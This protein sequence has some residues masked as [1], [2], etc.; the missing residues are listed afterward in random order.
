[1]RVPHRN[2]RS[3][4]LVGTGNPTRDDD[5]RHAERVLSSPQHRDRRRRK[6]RT[7][8]V[9]GDL[10]VLPDRDGKEARARRHTVRTR[11]KLAAGVQPCAKASQAVPAHL[12]FGPI[13]VPHPHGDG[14]QATVRIVR[15]QQKSIRADPEMAV[16]RRLRDPRH[17]LPTIA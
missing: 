10:A 8:H 9:Y 2:A 15:C 17:N 12:A 1:M 4:D 5:R 3:D 6:P 7:S 11:S 16:A 13:R 14:I